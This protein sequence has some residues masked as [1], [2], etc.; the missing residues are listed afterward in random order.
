MPAINDG[1]RSS[2][3]PA[4]ICAD[5]HATTKYSGGV[6]S[7]LSATN[8]SVPGRSCVV[9]IQYVESS[10]PNRL[11]PAT[12]SR[13]A[14]PITVS[15]ATAIAQARPCRR[16]GR[17]SPARAGSA[18]GVACGAEETIR[19][20]PSTGR[21][22][23]RLVP[24]SELVVQLDTPLPAALPAG[25]S[26]AVFLLGACFHRRKRISEL[27]LL[28]DGVAQPPA[29]WAMP[30]P[31]VA[32]AGGVPRSGF[33]GTVTLAPRAGGAVELA[34]RARLDGGGAAI[35]PLGSIAIAPADGPAPAGSDRIAVCMATFEPDPALF[36]AQVESLRGQTDERWV[37]VISDDCS[38]PER[39][40]EIVARVADDRGSSSRDP[41][42]GSASIAT[43]SAPCGSRRPR[44]SCSR[45]ATRTIA[46]TPTSSPR[47]ERRS[48]RPRWSTPTS[49]SSKRTG[50]C[51][52]TRCGRAARTTTR[53]WC[54]CSSPTASPAPRRCSVARSRGSRCRFPTRRGCRSTTTGSGSSRSRPATWRTSTARCTTT[55]STAARSSAP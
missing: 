47:C 1:A 29:A 42:C 12:S 26:D 15:A 14:A 52:A 11:C 6:I 46:G 19:A 34:I 51:S 25:R 22:R 35:A 30:R 32:A 24:D 40:R 4:S 9:T 18:T 41:T 44:P 49:A 23:S 16:A 5:S 13:S 3:G 54:R 38:A 17:C 55:C 50:A 33:W 2:S 43:S 39:Y 28:V 53:T 31:D 21:L 37:C 8:E 36:A 48:A 20:D 7:I 45:S 10:S 27:A